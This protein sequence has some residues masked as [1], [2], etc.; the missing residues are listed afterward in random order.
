MGARTRQDSKVR[1]KWRDQLPSLER[2]LTDLD[3]LPDAVKKLY[4]ARDPGRRSRSFCEKAQAADVLRK[5]LRGLSRLLSEHPL[6][7]SDQFKLTFDV[8]H[9]RDGFLQ[10]VPRKRSISAR[11]GH[12]PALTK[13]QLKSSV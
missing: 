11:S 8:A 6:A 10:L 12:L 1:P 9:R 2:E 5:L 4:R 13:V 3:A 7:A